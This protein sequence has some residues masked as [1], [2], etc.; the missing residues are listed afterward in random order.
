MLQKV[1]MIDRVER[2][3]VKR[4]GRGH[5]PAA[6]RRVHWGKI[7]I[8]PC[9]MK[10]PTAAEIEQGWRFRRRGCF[11]RRGIHHAAQQTEVRDRLMS[12]RPVKS[13]ARRSA[14][15]PRRRKYSSTALR[16][17]CQWP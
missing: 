7:E 14:A 3:A 10:T 8:N 12:K 2:L 1:R 5:V 4:Q 11:R 9:R 13:M 6:D 16:A 17:P 15:M